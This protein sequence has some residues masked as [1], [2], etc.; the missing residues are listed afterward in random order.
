MS[1]K[2]RLLTFVALLVVLALG[3]TLVAFRGQLPL[4]PRGEPSVVTFEQLDRD[5][6]HVEVMGTLHYPVRVTQ[7]FE[8]T[9][10]RPEPPTQHIFP[11]FAKGDTMGREIRVLVLSE[12]EPDRMF[13]LEDRLVRGEIERPNS[14]L[15]NRGVLDTFHE[16][17]Y[18]FDADFLL[19]IE[20]PPSASGR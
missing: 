9:W 8:A 10:L 13:G 5:S 3:G 20:D 6:G 17:S 15:L 12:V 19:L 2:H 1:N 16:H 7:T 11:L 18:Q 4:L 14:R